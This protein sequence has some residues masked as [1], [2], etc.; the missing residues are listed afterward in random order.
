MKKKKRKGER[1]SESGSDRRRSRRHT[2]GRAETPTMRTSKKKQKQKTKQILVLVTVSRGFFFRCFGVFFFC[3]VVGRFVR[4]FVQ[5]A[6]SFFWRKYEGTSHRV[7]VK[8]HTPHRLGGNKFG[9]KRR[10]R[11]RER[12]GAAC[13]SNAQQRWIARERHI[14]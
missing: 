14:F 8:R 5:V 10:R 6:R 2:N 7:R 1:E 4:L 13:E 9:I 12:R 11:A 3:R